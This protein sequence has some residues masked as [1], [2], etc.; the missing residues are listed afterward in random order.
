MYFKPE[1]N[2]CLD[3]GTAM[4]DWLEKELNATETGDFLLAMHVYPGLSLVNGAVQT[5]WQAAPTQR[6]AEILTEQA[7]KISLVAGA[8]AHQMRIAAPV[9][10]ETLGGPLM[11]L[12][13]NP[14]VSPVAGNNPSMTNLVLDKST[15]S[16]V[17][18][19]VMSYQLQNHLTGLSEDAWHEMSAKEDFNMQIGADKTA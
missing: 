4:L 19:T 15:N 2:V 16:V 1:N 6:F 18:T 9:V 3:D 17:D 14:A 10:N 13:A 11:P 5:L 7:S 8:N 12:F